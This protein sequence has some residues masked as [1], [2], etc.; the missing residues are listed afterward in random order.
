MS[1]IALF[2]RHQAQ[3]GRRDEVQRI[4]ERHVKPRVQANP[5]HEAY[6]FCYDN[7]DPDVVCVFQLYTDE[8][9]MQEFLSGSWYPAY[10]N[11]VSQVVA[12]PPQIS[13]ATLVWSK[14]SDATRP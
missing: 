9:A 1:K 10:L 2:I 11:E 6:F 4:W 14:S 7:S 13:P 12:A 8:A 3:P 5:A